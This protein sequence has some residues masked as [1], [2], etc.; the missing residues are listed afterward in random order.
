[1]PYFG[2]QDVYLRFM[3]GL[4]TTYEHFVTDT[5]IW[6]VV[7]MSAWHNSLLAEILEATQDDFYRNQ[8]NDIV[9]GVR[10]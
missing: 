8:F 7:P 9:D 6:I 1:M 5:S 2:P 3:A 4:T 10:L